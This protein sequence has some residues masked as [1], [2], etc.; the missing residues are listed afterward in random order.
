MVGGMAFVFYVLR[1]ALS[2][3][4]EDPAMKP[5]SSFIRA[6]F[7]WVAV[8]LTAVI[9]AS[10][11][12]NIIIAPPKGWY[13]LVLVVKVLLAGAVLSLYFRNAFA[14]AS[15]AASPEPSPAPPADAAGVSSPEKAGEWKTAWLLAPRASQVKIE[16]ILIAGALLVILLGV[17]LNQS[18]AV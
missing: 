15:G 16:L 4:A 14:K 9:I 1:P 17:I 2:R 3:H 12:V 8:L 6:R 11:V 13:I 10:G 18:S 5:V 7:R